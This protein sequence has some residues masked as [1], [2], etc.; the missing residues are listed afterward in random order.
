MDTTYWG[1]NFGVMLFKDSITKE[2]LL[3]YYVKYETNS[4]YR[5][6]IE[7]LKFKSEQAVL[8]RKHEANIKLMDRDIKAMELS[9]SSGIALEKIKATLSE[10]SAKLRTQVA[11]AKDKTAKPAEQVAEPIVEPVGRATEGYAFQE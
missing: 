5:K 1:T 7:E 11:L 9:A 8:D 4:L 6:G 10:S 3:K 2:N